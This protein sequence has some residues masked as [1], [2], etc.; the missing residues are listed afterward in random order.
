M[1]DLSPGRARDGA[2]VMPIFRA[3]QTKV[4]A[5]LGSSNTSL[6]KL[7]ITSRFLWFGQSLC[8]FENEEFLHGIALSHH[9]GEIVNYQK[10]CL[11]D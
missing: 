5:T 3:K 11:Y 2:L 6:E 1:S 4:Y 7:A 8:L 10:R 9:Q